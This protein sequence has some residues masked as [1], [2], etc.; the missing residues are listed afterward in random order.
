MQCMDT[1]VLITDRFTSG[2]LGVDT[3]IKSLQ[4]G[5]AMARFWDGE[6]EKEDLVWSTMWTEPYNSDLI[7]A[8]LDQFD[9]A[10]LAAYAI[11]ACAAR[12]GTAAIAT[13]LL[14]EL[15]V[16]HTALLCARATRIALIEDPRAGRPDFSSYYDMFGA[17]APFS[18]AMSINLEACAQPLQPR[19]RQSTLG[20]IEVLLAAVE[21]ERLDNSVTSDPREQRRR[22][23]VIVVPAL[24][25][26]GLPEQP[27]SCS[28]AQGAARM[29][30]RAGVCALHLALERIEVLLHEHGRWN[31]HG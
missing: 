3:S 26:D 13:S 6:A 30:L 29:A 10:Y 1:V 17:E 8:L 27:D 20:N 21:Q 24:T 11:Q 12:T 5:I 31:A 23:S 18:R 9:A 25:A 14:V 28:L 19:R 16:G 2:D 15:G 4:G 22:D 7:H